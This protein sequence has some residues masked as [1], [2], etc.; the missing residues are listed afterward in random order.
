MAV[1]AF[2]RTFKRARESDVWPTA[3]LLL[4]VL[5]PA[6]CLLWFM[7]AAIHNERLAAQQRLAEAYRGQLA[8]SREGVDR[9]LEATA[10]LL[11]K[12][13]NAASAPG[14]FENCIRLGRVESGL[15][16]GTNGEL[17]YPSVPKA[18]KRI[19]EPTPAW[20]EAERQ[21]N[22][23]KDYK[24]AAQK[25][26]SIAETSTNTT[27]AARALQAEIRCL[28][29]AQD[30]EAAKRV[31]SGQLNHARFE[32][33]L[34]LQGRSIIANAE[35]MALELTPNRES[36]EFKS[37]V[38]NLGAR[39]ERYDGS[40]LASPQRRFLMTELNRLAPWA[41]ASQFVDAE[42]LAAAVWATE[43]RARA[44]AQAV[45]PLMLR[46]VWGV[47]SANHRVLGLIKTEHLMQQLE[48]AATLD[49]LPQDTQLRLIPPGSPSENAF[50]SLPL[51]KRLPGW[52]LALN[53]AEEN[54]FFAA[55]RRQKQMYLWT[56]VLTLAAVVILSLLAVRM[57]RQ[58]LAL[59]RMKNDLVSTVSHELRTPLAAMRVLVDTLLQGEK[60]GAQQT[61]EYL[62]LISKENEKLSRIVQNF[63]T[64]SRME[65]Q[66]HTF[67][68]DFVPAA[69]IVDAAAW[70]LRERYDLQ[71]CRLEVLKDSGPAGI[72]A[73][74][75]ALTTALTNLLDNAYKY[76][77]E[78][79]HIRLRTWAENGNVLFSVED[80]G[81]GIDRDDVERV[82][83]QFYQGEK[84]LARQTGG[85][86]LGLSIVKFI[87]AAH[88]GTVWAEERRTA[89]SKFIIS[90]PA[91][92]RYEQRDEE[93][94]A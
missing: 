20:L 79:K 9:Y 46:G 14:A 49:N 52:Q 11:D 87:V 68:F 1:R 2:V 12:V 45:E 77:P 73:D 66:K 56:G 57:M 26:A 3:I 81:D 76:T 80:N 33:A 6:L 64:F 13:G 5:V 82:F 74:A 75:D 69:E 91:T 8:A 27:T 71:N 89:G 65:R 40:T 4:A 7:N 93:A 67:A 21:E 55:A 23:E 90:L 15:I 38:R 17:L 24:G 48:K 85:C 42:E 10:E 92:A 62:Q 63:L 86:G 16:F 39:L 54:P 30:Y 37:R 94:I 78:I 18:L 29:R 84:G 60:P 53:L 44:N 72:T 36:E 31:F 83:E 34:D 19:G 32:G 35:L 41:V 51:G 47:P 61:Q 25:Y 50:V 70:A 22:F 58:Q 88:G 28:A 59:T 43:N